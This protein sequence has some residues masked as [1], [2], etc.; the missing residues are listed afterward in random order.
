MSKVR[1]HKK[2]QAQTGGGNKKNSTKK[3]RSSIASRSSTPIITL[4][5]D[6]A[7]QLSNIASRKLRESKELKK[8]NKELTRHHLK[9]EEIEE[10]KVAALQ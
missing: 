7:T 2:K 1:S 8:R 6:V 5:D 10:K 9:L 4:D 3:R